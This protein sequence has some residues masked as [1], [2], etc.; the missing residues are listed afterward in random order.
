MMEIGEIFFVFGLGFNS[1]RIWMDE[2]WFCLWFMLG[3]MNGDR[4]GGLKDERGCV[5][6]NEREGKF[7]FFG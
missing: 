4:Y 6:L 3:M 7:F 1:V 5:V 2:S